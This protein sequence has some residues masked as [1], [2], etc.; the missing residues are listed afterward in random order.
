MARSYNTVTLVGNLGAD[1]DVRTLPA[2]GSVASFSV[3]TTERWNQGDRKIESTQWHRVVA[4]DSDR[5][6]LGKL[7]ADYLHKGDRVM[8]VGQLKYSE[9][10]DKDGVTR[11][12]AEITA[13][14]VIFLSAPREE[15]EPA[16]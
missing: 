10:T 5:V 11:R 3:A 9:Y 16:P 12:N 1:P 4:F 8:I 15:A 7:C 6:K 14:E 2:G 13:R